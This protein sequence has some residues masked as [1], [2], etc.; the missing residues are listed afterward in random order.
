[1]ALARGGATETVVDGKTGLLVDDSSAPALADGIARALSASF[2]RATIRRNAERFSRERFVN[3]IS[4]LVAPS[5]GS[6]QDA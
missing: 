3:E 4:E 5:T 2:D 6:G 1:V